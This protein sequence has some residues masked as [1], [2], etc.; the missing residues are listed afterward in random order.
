MQDAAARAAGTR[1]FRIFGVQLPPSEST[2]RTLHAISIEESGDELRARFCG[3]GF[4]RGMV[5][6]ICGVLSDA[7][8]GRVPPGRVTELLED[9]DRRGLSH[10]SAAKG[11]TLAGVSYSPWKPLN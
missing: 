9:G 2:V 11:L 7:S 8:R 6:S 10:K 5:R 3:D 4:L 1:D